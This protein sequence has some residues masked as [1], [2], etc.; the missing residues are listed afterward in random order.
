MW[1]RLAT[2]GSSPAVPGLRVTR[3][4]DNLSSRV[5][6][7]LLEP[8][9]IIKNAAPLGRRHAS[10][11]NA[12]GGRPR[13]TPV[14]RDGHQTTQIGRGASGRGG[15]GAPVAGEPRAEAPD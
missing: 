5:A 12:A 7:R 1:A 9:G 4:T 15:G 3:L 13:R 2:P 10:E 6:T 8:E 14:G 11:A